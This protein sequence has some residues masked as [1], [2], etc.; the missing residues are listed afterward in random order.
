M[1]YVLTVLF[2]LFSHG[3]CSTNSLADQHREIP[4]GAS[5]AD[6][7]NLW[8]QPEE[9]VLK[10]VKHEVFWYY[11]D[12]GLVVFRNGQVHKWLYP[13]KYRA[14]SS[15]ESKGEQK[16]VE[17]D[18][19]GANLVRDM[20]EAVQESSVRSVTAGSAQ[21]LIDRKPPLLR[22]RSRSGPQGVPIGNDDT[23]DEEDID[24]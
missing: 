5:M 17:V 21:P 15:D 24:E 12:E 19:E 22:N 8:G 20:A 9:K 1:K 3:V 18:V 2:V 7:L 6:V 13:Q 11:P 14:L 4:Q 10:E 16:S 23:D